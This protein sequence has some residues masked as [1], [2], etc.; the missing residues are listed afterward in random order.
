MTRRRRE[1]FRFLG[2]VA[3]ADTLFAV[4]AGL[5]LLNPIRFAP[6]AAPLPATASR[7]LSHPT[8][9]VAPSPALPF[10]S[11]DAELAEA[12]SLLTELEAS[13]VGVEHRVRDATETESQ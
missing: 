10:S 6:P 4:S 2:F 12:E 13:V 3:L 11:L 7:P 1:G 5:L 8:P 9:E